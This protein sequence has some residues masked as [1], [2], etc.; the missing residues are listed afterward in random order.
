VGPFDQ[1]LACK[2]V[3]MKP[4]LLDE[5]LAYV[6]RVSPAV[7]RPC[8]YPTVRL[9]LALPTY[10]R[11]LRRLRLRGIDVWVAFHQQWTEPAGRLDGNAPAHI[12][13]LLKMG[14]HPVVIVFRGS[15]FAIFAVRVHFQPLG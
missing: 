13:D 9:E 2:Y 5:F 4:N 6:T 10:S 3:R 15:F 8:P 12:L 11:G 7:G 14:C 1:D